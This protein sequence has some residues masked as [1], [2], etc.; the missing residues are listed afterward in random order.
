[1]AQV[2]SRDGTQIEFEKVG[3]G[4]AVILVHGATAYGLLESWG[5]LPALLSPHFT[6]YGYDRRGRGKSTDTLPFA[7][8]REIEDL[9]ALIT[10]AGGSAFAHGVS[11]GA[12]LVLKAAASGLNVTKISLYEPPYYVESEGTHKADGYTS[13][14]NEALSRG[15]RGDA[16]AAFLRY[17]GLPEEAIA[18]MRHAPMW[19]GME[20]IAPTLAYDNAALGN[21]TVPA[22]LA[23]SVTIPT[24]V[25]NGDASFAFMAA[26]APALAEALPNG[27]HHT[28]AGQT[29]DADP[30]VLAPVLI[31]FFNS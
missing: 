28:L 1:M 20:A 4:P 13:Q 27:Q 21:S 31:E 19:A 5:D 6:V 25:A 29:H 12:A 3:Q 9:E 16:V 23:S 11:S 26:S 30:K 15:S 17:V 7:V 22:A 24:L 10:D 14:L 18:G 8:E 2:I